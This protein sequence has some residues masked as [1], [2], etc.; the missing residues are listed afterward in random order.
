MA[1][2]PI[3]RWFDGEKRPVVLGPLIKSGGAGS[4]YHLDAGK[5]AKL[6]HDTIDKAY[7]Q[8][9][10]AAMLAL[11]PQLPPVAGHPVIQ[12]A[13]PLSPVFSEKGHFAGFIMPELDVKA[14][15]ELEYILQE[16]QARAHQLPVGLGAKIS[17]AANL[18]TIVAALHQ[19]QHRIIDL[20]PINLRFYKESLYVA[21]LDCDGFSI[22]GQKER[23]P[24]NQFTA[25]YLAPEFQ[26]TGRIAE[27]QEEFQDRFALAVILFQLLNFGIHPYS[28]RPLRDDM[29]TDLPGRIR[30]HAYGYGLKKHPH[31]EPSPVSG[32]LLMPQEI[33]E[34]FEKAFSASPEQRPSAQ[35]WA[36]CLRRY[37]LRSGDLLKVCAKNPEH[38]YFTGHACAAC[39]RETLLKQTAQAQKK[40][41]PRR[42]KKKVHATAAARA[43]VRQAPRPIPAAAPVPPPPP[44]PPPVPAGPPTH[45]RM[46]F[47]AVLSVA[48]PVMIAWLMMQFS[49][50]I[51]KDYTQAI[52]LF[53]DMIASDYIEQFASGMMGVLAVMVLCIGAL[54]LIVLPFITIRGSRP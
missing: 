13:W 52:D 25:E 5:V 38:Q 50:E 9:K 3:P 34:L 1:K 45:R 15:I 35:S 53:K 23:F 26:A 14:S 51:N 40:S 48:I 47:Y 12:I 7:H 4:V 17:L 27:A 6:Y 20:K 31:I 39:A 11:A 18:C 29:P 49:M 43:A 24:A 33:R 42:Q 41:A 22:R 21:M 19:Q 16:R 8:R 44:P 2:P 37:A 54:V 46:G 32:H 28:G 30:R 10:V 36:Q